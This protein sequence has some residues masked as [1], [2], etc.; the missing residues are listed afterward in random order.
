MTARR[1]RLTALWLALAVLPAAAGEATLVRVTVT[2]VRDPGGVLMV[3]VYDRPDNWLGVPPAKS[4]EV[5][6]AP[7]LRDG[8]VALELRLPPGRYA[9]SLFQDLNGNRH[10]DTNFLG[11]PKEA[12]GSSNNP[13]ARWGPPKFADALVTVGDAPLELSIRLE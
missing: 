7:N 3:G 4:I 8:S 9:L 6:V 13:P 10:L 12:S 5:P 2:N 11:I 1:R